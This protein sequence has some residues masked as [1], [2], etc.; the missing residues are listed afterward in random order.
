MKNVLMPYLNSPQIKSCV[1]AAIAL[2]TA[3]YPLQKAE[4]FTADFSQTQNFSAGAVGS[5]GWTGA[6]GGNNSGSAFDSNITS[7][8]QL[9]IADMGG[10]WEGDSNTGHLLYVSVTGDFT[11]T[12]KLFSISTVIYSSAGIGAF[13]PSITTETPTKSWIGIGDSAFKSTVLQRNVTGG[14]QS[15]TGDVGGM[16]APV[17]LQLSRVGDVFT[18]AYSLTGA[19][20]S[21]TQVDSATR[22]DLGST[23]NVGLWV[24]SFTGYTTTATFDSFTVVPEPATWMMVLG[25]LGMVTMFRRRRA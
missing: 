5:T 8:G 15:D 18:T 14:T 20:G 16:D 4:A 7:A 21:F 9:T 22:S 24:A 23:V 13:D 3:I 12:T 17:Y 11:A 1:I 2:G 6:Y 25:G 10:H 19:D